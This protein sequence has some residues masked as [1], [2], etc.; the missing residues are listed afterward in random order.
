MRYAVKILSL[1]LAISMLFAVPVFAANVKKLPD[2][3]EAEYFDTLADVIVEIFNFDITKDELLERTIHNLLVTNPGAL[4]EF[5]KALFG[6]LDE[7]SQF[8]TPKEWK[9]L[10]SNL[11]GV[12]GGI[13]VEMGN[14]GRTLVIEAVIDDSPAQKAG[15]RAG[16]RILEVDG[17]DVS[18]MQHSLVRQMI[19]G[20]IGTEVTVKVQRGEEVL[21]FQIIRAQLT[22]QTVAYEMLQG[23]VAYLKIATFNQGTDTELDEALAQLDT[24]G[25]KKII[26]DLRNNPGGYVDVAVNI[27]RRFVPKGTVATASFKKDDRKEVYTSDLG[28]TKYELVVLVNENTASAA[29]ILASA[30]QDS[31]A[32]KLIGRTTYGKA[33]IQQLFALYSGPDGQRGCKITTGA[34]LTRDG[35]QI[36]HVGINP[37][38]DIRNQI[39]KY[40]E[41]P[42]DKMVYAERYALGDNGKGIAVAKQRLRVLG[43]YLGE[44]GEE[45]T[46]E[47]ADA[48]ELFQKDVAYEVTGVLD[49][50]TQIRLENEAITVDVLLDRQ[51]DKAL[52]L[53]GCS[54]NTAA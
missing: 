11:Q 16:D 1:I 52:E 22:E 27:A 49:I 14:R 10:L 9:A 4:D 12:F 28:A 41:I 45:Y 2:S 15:L 18:E 19:T 54:E 3:A 35:K 6:S 5:L 53:F 23:D 32:G 8:Y 50:Y 36:N 24:Y 7:Y 38:Y 31:G 13:G 42:K 44:M 46:Q 29:E 26:L 48:V 34:Y 47:L 37:D 21:T 43:Y 39:V 20:E 25:V 51:M 30:I 17:E 40:D 33:V